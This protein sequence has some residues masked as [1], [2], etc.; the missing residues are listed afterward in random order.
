MKIVWNENPTWSHVVLEN[1]LDRKIFRHAI[2][3]DRYIDH[4]FSKWWELGKSVKAAKTL[5]EIQ[6][7]EDDDV[8]LT[9]EEIKRM[10]D[11]LSDGHCGDCTCVPAS[12]AQ[13]IAEDILGISTI[14]EFNKYELRY[15]DG[16]FTQVSTI[17]EA[18]TFLGTKFPREKTDVWDH[19]SDE[20]W[21]KLC[22]RWDKDR[23]SASRKLSDYKLKHGF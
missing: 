11:F 7:P 14:S 22:D 20:D 18:I 2:E 10:T 17:D 12:C 13:C 16:A 3:Q 19:Y 8:N 23:E 9:D 15:I 1:D 5:E 6:I 4:I 21:Q